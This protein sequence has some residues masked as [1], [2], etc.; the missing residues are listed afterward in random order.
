MALVNR[1]EFELN[2][3]AGIGVNTVAI[4]TTVVANC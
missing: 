1:T 3:P 2:I 4:D